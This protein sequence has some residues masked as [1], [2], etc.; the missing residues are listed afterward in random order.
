MGRKK[1]QELIREFFEK[2][3]KEEFS[4][5]EL[6]KVLDE[7][8]ALPLST[9]QLSTKL[10]NLVRSGFLVRRLNVE[11]NRGTP[12]NTKPRGKIYLYHVNN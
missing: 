6:S 10:I 9:R 2:H 3:K 12:F 4:A 5:F 8:F 7:R 1:I 11:R